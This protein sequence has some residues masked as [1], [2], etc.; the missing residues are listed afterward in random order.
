MEDVLASGMAKLATTEHPITVPRHKFNMQGLQQE[1]ARLKRGIDQGEEVLAQAGMTLPEAYPIWLKK[2]IRWMASPF[3]KMKLHSRP[4][5]KAEVKAKLADI[6]EAFK[7]INA[8]VV[9]G[10]LTPLTLAE[11]AE[12]NAFYYMTRRHLA[13]ALPQQ[14]TAEGNQAREEAIDFTCNHAILAKRVECCL[15]KSER[16]GWE[17]G[18]RFVLVQP[19]TRA[20]TPEQAHKLD[21]R[22]TADIWAEYQ[23][24]FVLSE[25]ELGK[26][27]APKKASS[28]A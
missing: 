11:E 15:K 6:Q 13:Q 8:D 25:D 3:L 16:E 22:L 12:C 7:H 14:P 18:G 4:M 24:I 17:P 21:P 9:E 27:V 20:L 10:I 26:Y 19:V 5:A 1:A 28:A 2:L 23:A